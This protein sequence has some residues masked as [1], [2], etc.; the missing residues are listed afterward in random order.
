MAQETFKRLCESGASHLEP[1]VR[2][3]WIYATSTRIAIDLLRRR[4][5]GVVTRGVEDQ[6]GDGA[7]EPSSGHPRLDDTLAARQSLTAIA[8]STPPRELQVAVLCRLDGL[9]QSEAAA[10][11]A[12]SQRSVRRLLARFDDRVAR[13]GGSAP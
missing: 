2:L 12:I 5:L 1:E 7:A 13:L 4:K 6:R 11:C 10:V 9:T 8:S 3:R